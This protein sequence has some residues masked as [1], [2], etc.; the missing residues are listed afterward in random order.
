ME[1]GSGLKPPRRERSWWLLALTAA[2]GVLAAGIAGVVSAPAWLQALCVTVGV[3]S[4]VLLVEL[5][6]RRAQSE[7]HAVELRSHVAGAREQLPT[8][9]AVGLAE[10]GV[11]RAIVKVPYVQRDAETEAKRALQERGRVLIVG[12]AMA[13]KSRLGL[14]V[15]QD[16]FA[17]HEFLKPSHGK[18]LHQLMV[19]GHRP[20]RMLVWLDRL[21][22]FLAEGL[23][24]DDLDGFCRDGTVAVATIGSD[25]Y[26]GHVPMD[27]LKAT[28]WDVLEWFAP[29]VW[30]TGWTQ[31]DLQRAKA[32]VSPQVLKAASRYGLSVYLGAGPVAIERFRAGESTCP[33]G[34]ALVRAAADWRRVGRSSAVPRE[35][36]VTVLPA[37]LR[38]HTEDP[39]AAVG[40]GR[41]WA[42]K[43]LQNTV[44]L[45]EETSDGHEVLDY[46]VEFLTEQELAIPE[47]MWDAAE[48]GAATGE[49]LDVALEAA[50]HG[51]ED[52]AEAAW[53]RA[54]DHPIAMYN[55]GVLHDRRG[56]VGEAER[57]WRVAAEEGDPGAMYRLHLLFLQQGASRAA[58]AEHWAQ[59]SAKAAARPTADKLADAR[60]RSAEV[61]IAF[62]GAATDA[63]QRFL[64]AAL[65]GYMA[66]L[67]RLGA[68]LGTVPT[69]HI[70]PGTDAS[71]PD[72]ARQRLF[73]GGRLAESPDA[74][75]HE[76]SHWVLDSLARGTRDAWT[77]DIKGVESGL[78]YYLPCSF[79]NSPSIT[80][81]DLRNPSRGPPWLG[82]EH[83]AGLG[84]AGALWEVRGRLGQQALDQPLLATWRA[85]PATGVDRAGFTDRLGER[86]QGAIGPSARQ[87]VQAALV[88]SELLK[89]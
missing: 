33:E 22:R 42:T 6:T 86:L 19:E 47:A 49:V 55:L 51:R 38:S 53:Q 40:T 65:R 30:L 62:S 78:A 12:P 58:E 44:A 60:V 66:Y 11:D 73:I 72:P 69:V 43:R 85:T 61:R 81:L 64:T 68:P 28:G 46:V 67:E 32:V 82:L 21:E 84:W 50:R 57:W 9:G 56:E 79:R 59:L 87:L 8:V 7:Q 41:D 45:L 89:P 77:D 63:Q 26:D 15:A 31:G 74:L 76:Y 20:Q 75:L 14:Q 23:T 83:Q 70:E 37:Y 16:L 5:Q 13:G 48:R 29:P 27:D 35:V 24:F 80:G 34:H 4:G 10:A 1:E 71:Y 25:A 17:Q 36:L 3:A 39:E 54:R 52:R 18:A 88:R 2:S